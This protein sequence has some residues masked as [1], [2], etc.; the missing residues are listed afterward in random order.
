MADKY[1]AFG[2]K[3]GMI[4]GSSLEDGIKELIELNQ[5]DSDLRAKLPI[6]SEGDREKAKKIWAKFTDSKKAKQA[7]KTIITPAS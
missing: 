6:I 2:Y 5:E 1:D 7:I 3:Y 4:E